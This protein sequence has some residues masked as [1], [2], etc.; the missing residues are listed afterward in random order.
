MTDAVTDR[1]PSP[2]ATTTGI[3]L[4]AEHVE[5]TPRRIRVRLGGRLVA[6]SSRALLM[7]RIG[8]KGLP[9][10]F[11]PREDVAPGVLVDAA[12]DAEGQSV[13]TVRAGPDEAIAAAWTDAHPALAGYVTFS[14]RQLDWYE[15]DEQVWAHARSPYG[16]V[17]TLYSSRQV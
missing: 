12:P 17:D 13:W 9:T 7:L 2:I 1:A 10:Y 6:D 14:W 8:P 11:L 4:T 16:R 3:D 5:P 15:E